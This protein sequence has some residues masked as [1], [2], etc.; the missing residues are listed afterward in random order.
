[1]IPFTDSNTA[2]NIRL[3]SYAKEQKSFE[4]EHVERERMILSHCWS[5]KTP[6]PIKW[7]RY[8]SVE[9]RTY[10]GICVGII[11]QFFIALTLFLGSRKFDHSFGFFSQKVPA[12]DCRRG[13]EWYV[14]CTVSSGRI[15]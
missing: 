10:A 2:S 14:F 8:A 5:W 6:Q 12:G 7:I 15:I 9:R 4:K 3:H 1:M 13:A 11:L